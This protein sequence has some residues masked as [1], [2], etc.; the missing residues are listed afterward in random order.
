MLFGYVSAA[1]GDCKAFEFA[2]GPA[3]LDGLWFVFKA[4]DDVGRI[5]RPITPANSH[6]VDWTRIASAIDYAD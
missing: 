3:N 5:L 6:F 1:C 4:K 2:S